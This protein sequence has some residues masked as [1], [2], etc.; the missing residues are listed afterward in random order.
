MKKLMVAS[1]S[2]IVVL[3]AAL[4]VVDQVGPPTRTAQLPR[5]FYTEAFDQE[6]DVYFVYFWRSNCPR[7][8]EFQPY[9]VR[10][11]NAGTPVF[12][13]DMNNNNNQDAWYRRGEHRDDELI[14]R[15]GDATGATHYSQIELTIEGTP[16]L[17]RIENGVL[18]DHVAGV[19]PAV[20]LLET[21]SE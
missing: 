18:T 5:I 12:I 3:L 14:G 20:Q 11:F 9:V 2:V 6:E 17:V 15:A 8:A 19:S 7:C 16:T 13:V 4:V 10:A 21:F 1:L